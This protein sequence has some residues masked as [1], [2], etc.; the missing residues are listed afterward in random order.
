MIGKI[1]E[2]TWPEGLQMWWWGWGTTNGGW[3]APR[4]P[5]GDRWSAPA[6]STFERF[7]ERREKLACWWIT[8][9][10]FLDRWSKFYYRA[11]VQLV[12]LNYNKT[13]IIEITTNYIC[14]FVWEIL[15]ENVNLCLGTWQCMMSQKNW[16]QDMSY[17]NH[18]NTEW[19]SNHMDLILDMLKQEFKV[20]LST[21]N[22]FLT[23]T[24][25]RH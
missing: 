12:N 19:D 17:L 10:V 24:N 15:A 1:S 25:C 8:N 3:A 11:R 6:L 7:S 22:Y 20:N 2:Q 9:R 5:T 14:E 18:P 21:L 16:D 23:T 13:K 4:A